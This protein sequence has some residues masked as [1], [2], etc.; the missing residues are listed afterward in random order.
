MLGVKQLLRLFNFGLG[1]YIMKRKF[2]FITAFLVCFTVLIL[3]LI[4]PLWLNVGGFKRSLDLNLLPTAEYLDMHPVSTPEFIGA[5]NPP[6]GSRIHSGE[7]ICLGLQP[8]ALSNAGESNGDISRNVASNVR[9]VINFQMLPI[10]SVQ[11][12]VIDTLEK[13]SD[14]RFSGQ[15]SVCFA[16]DLDKGVHIFQ[17]EFRNSPLGAFGLGDLYSYT[18]VYHVN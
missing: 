6:I 13:L 2:L 5:I 10:S 7:T 15:V 1:V 8:G 9:I 12:K 4:Y 18:W 16:P 14:G 11:V 17:I 3:I